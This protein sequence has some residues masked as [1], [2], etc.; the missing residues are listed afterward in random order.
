MEK[1]YVCK[2]IPLYTYENKN[3]HSFHISL[4]FKAGSIYENEGE[5]GITHFFEHAAIRNVAKIM[6][7]RLYPEL[8]RRGVEFNAS[9]YSEMVQFYTGGAPS[10][11]KFC[12]SLIIK[13]LSPI[14]LGKDGVDAER[15]R[16]KAELRE[17]EDKNSLSSLAAESVHEGTSLSRSILGTVGSV[18]KIGGKR[19]EEYRQK[20]TTE[21][22]F[23]FYVTG[24]FDK[25]DL[26]FLISEIEKYEIKKGEK[27]DNLA[28]VSQNFFKRGGSVRLKN[29]DSVSVRFTFDLDMSLCSMP[30]GDLIYDILFNGYSSPFFIKMSEEAG[31]FYDITSSSERYKNIGNIAVSYEVSEKN[32]YSSIKMAVDILNKFKSELLSE[33]D[34]M[35]STYV[36]NAEILL[37]D[38]RELA[39]TFAY[40]NHIMELGY[41]D[42]CDR[43]EKYQKITPEEIRAAA[44][45]IFTH[46]NL[47]LIVKGKKR[48]INLQKIKELISL[49]ER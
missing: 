20:I 39:F 8:D 44:G 30:L 21:G 25:R 14:I 31:L 15:K 23:F 35:K 5:C 26:E 29:C 2:G 49:L 13:I 45:K 11:F 7:D 16:I 19:L 22:N 17:S 12:S 32:L 4:F 46:D 42:V 41:K 3:L 18:N 28:P 37:D 36:K 10:N 34:L 43:A 6:N 47:T 9:T 38:P 1:M 48:K 27:R 33:E 40:D 24:N